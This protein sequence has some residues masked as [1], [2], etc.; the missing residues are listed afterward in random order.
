MVLG[1]DGHWTCDKCRFQ[2]H[3]A[4]NKLWHRFSCKPCWAYWNWFDFKQWIGK[5]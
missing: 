5:L 2:V 3:G 1:N 4:F